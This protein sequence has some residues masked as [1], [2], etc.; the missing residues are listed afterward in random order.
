M[1]DERSRTLCKRLGRSTRGYCRH[2]LAHEPKKDGQAPTEA[3]VSNKLGSSKTIP[4]SV[5]KDD[6]NK[7]HDRGRES[8]RDNILAHVIANGRWQQTRPSATN[9]KI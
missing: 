7:R 5:R 1:S 3:K 4:V 2:E 8:D 9:Q 6:E